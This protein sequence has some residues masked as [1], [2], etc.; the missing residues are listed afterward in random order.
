VEL[1]LPKTNRRYRLKA[2]AAAVYT[3]QSEV[4]QQTSD[5]R[6]LVERK[7]GGAASLER[8]HLRLGHLNPPA[9]QRM[10]RDEVATGM[11]A[12]LSEDMDSPCWSCRAAKMIRMSYKKTVTRRATRPF[13][14]LMSDMCYVE[15]VTYDGYEHFQLVQDEASRYLWGFMLYRKENA[16]D[17]VL[18]HLKWVWGCIAFIF[19]PRVLRKSKLENPGK[20]GLDVGLHSL[21]LH[22][23]SVAQEQAGEP[24]QTGFV[25]GICE[26]LG[27]LS[28]PELDHW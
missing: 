12:E 9:L 6:V 1:L 21:H 18:D 5:S 13:Q 28:H 3:V 11:K 19:T 16:S 8:W 23:Q 14:K 7:K 10:V 26:A 4:R 17:V 24:R 2:T 15:E 25:R 20:P 22:A 27:G